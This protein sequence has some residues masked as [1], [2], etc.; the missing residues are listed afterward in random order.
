MPSEVGITLGILQVLYDT[1]MALPKPHPTTLSQRITLLKDLLV[2]LPI[3]REGDVFLL[4][5]GVSHEFLSLLTL[6]CM[7]GHREGKQLGYA[8]FSQAVS[9]MY[10]ITGSTGWAPLDSDLSGKVLII[11]AFLP[12]SY[13]T[14]IAEVVAVFAHPKGSHLANGMARQAHPPIERSESF[15]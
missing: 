6:V 12:H 15:F 11:G 13:Y 1:P 7:Q 10:A 14:L 3:G 5:G 8:F 9:T 4:Y 2:S